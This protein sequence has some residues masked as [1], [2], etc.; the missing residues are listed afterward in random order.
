MVK[1]SDTTGKPIPNDLHPSRGASNARPMTQTTFFKKFDEF[2]DVPDAVATV[3]ESSANGSADTSLGRWPRNA[4]RKIAPPNLHKSLTQYVRLRS[5]QSRGD[6]LPARG[7]QPAK[8]LSSFPNGFKPSPPSRP[9]YEMANT[10]RLRSPQPF[11]PHPSSFIL[12]P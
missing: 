10:T 12:S 6:S 8:C 5:K 3:R 4:E 11:K 2:V 9:G 7:E 1:R